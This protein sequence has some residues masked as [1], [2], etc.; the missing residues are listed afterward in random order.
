M[1]L[2]GEAL[3]K[4]SVLPEWSVGAVLGHMDEGAFF[5]AG[6]LQAYGHG[7]PAQRSTDLALA[8]LLAESATALLNAADQVRDVR[9]QA[10]ADIYGRKAGMPMDML[11]DILDFEFA[12]HLRDL[13]WSLGSRTP[14]RDEAALSVLRLFGDHL[15]RIGSAGSAPDSPTSFSLQST[16]GNF[17]TSVCYLNGRWAKQKRRG[18]IHIA[19]PSHA[20]AMLILGR[21]DALDPWLI[22]DGDPLT[23]IKFNR[24]FPGPS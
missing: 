16:D 9:P 1:H 18:A 14:L 23:A 4:P 6:C 13:D 7:K 10:V 21:I 2:P 3:N 24:Y 15:H 17:E 5:L 11:A 8:A 22:L 19:G 12:T 20:L